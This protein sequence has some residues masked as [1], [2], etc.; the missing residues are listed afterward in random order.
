M[1]S[2]L[3]AGILVL[4]LTVTAAHAQTDWKQV[5]Q[6]FGREATEQPGG[7]HRFGLPR[8]DLKVT[9]DGVAIKPALAL[10]SWLAFKEMNG[11]A[12]VMGDLVLTEPEINPVMARL[13][14]DGIAITALHNHLLRAQPATFYL[15]VEGHGDP[16]KLAQTL[17]SALEQSQTPLALPPASAAEQK[18]PELDTA[19]LERVFGRKGKMSGGVYQLAI[20]RAETVNADGTEV[21]ASMGTAIAINFQPLDGG[22]AA[23]TGDLVL[24]AE[25]VNPALHALGEHG[26]EV[27]AIHNHMLMDEPRLFF[28][29]FWGV[30]KAEKLAEGLKAALD[31]VNVAKS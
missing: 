14:E 13:A 24:R 18:A 28:L 3:S 7:V 12:M 1:R 19:A 23:T 5:E 6:V 22:R 4:S 16:G 8:A 30:D 31:K 2:V 27:T 29:H 10:G 21:P 9:V 17:R 15:H 20:P 26:L 11:G 25:E